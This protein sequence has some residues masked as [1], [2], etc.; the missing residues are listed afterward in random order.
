MKL[1]RQVGENRQVVLPYLILT[2]DDVLRQADI[3]HVTRPTRRLRQFHSYL[4]RQLIALLHIAATA[5]ADQVL[6]RCFP[7]MPFGNNV[8]DCKVLGCGPT[9]LAHV[10]IARKHSPTGE[11]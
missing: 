7:S 6:P 11:F 4:M 9:I 1:L 10:V 3:G 2:P 5:A 8:V